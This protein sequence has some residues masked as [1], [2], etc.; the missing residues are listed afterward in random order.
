MIIKTKHFMGWI[1]PKRINCIQVREVVVPTSLK[2]YQPKDRWFVEVYFDN[3][4][5]I[6]VERFEDKEKALNFVEELD[7]KIKKEV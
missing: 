6:L 7:K 5:P 3:E 2:K 4:T 1:N